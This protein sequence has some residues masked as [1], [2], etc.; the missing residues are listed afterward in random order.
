MASFASLVGYALPKNAAE[1]S[2][3]MLPA[4]KD[5]TDKTRPRHV[6][7]NSSNN[8]F[9]I[10]KDDWELIDAKSGNVTAMPEWFAKENN[11]DNNLPAGGGLYNLKQEIGER[12][13]LIDEHPEIAADLRKILKDIRQSG[14]SAPRLEK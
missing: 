2:Y 11:Y 4:L 9:A 3:D 13:N 10:R 5:N 8:K 6:H 14:H 1:D 12:K 7:V